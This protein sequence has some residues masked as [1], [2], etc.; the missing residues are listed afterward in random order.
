[1]HVQEISKTLKIHINWSSR[2]TAEK[3]TFIISVYNSDSVIMEVNLIFNVG[4]LQN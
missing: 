3:V 1:M 4:F 2:F